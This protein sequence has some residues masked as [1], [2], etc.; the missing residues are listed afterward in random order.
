MHA[1]TIRLPWQFFIG[2]DGVVRTTTD[3]DAAMTTLALARQ[4]LTRLSS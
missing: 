4:G 1:Q 2:P 3:S